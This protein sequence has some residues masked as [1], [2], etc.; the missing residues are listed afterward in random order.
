M[1]TSSTPMRAG[2]VGLPPTSPSRSLFFRMPLR[3]KSMKYPS[4]TAR[5]HFKTESE[6]LLWMDLR[7]YPAYITLNSSPLKL[8]G[9]AGLVLPPCYFLGRINVRGERCERRK[10][11][12]MSDRAI[13]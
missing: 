7:E 13:S 10:Y 2:V 11:K 8:W 4:E 5:R 1:M 12:Q 6:A 3:G 9:L